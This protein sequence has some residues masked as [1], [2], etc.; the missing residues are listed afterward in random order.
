MSFLIA[1]RNVL[2]NRRRTIVTLLLSIVATFF[3]IFYGAVFNGMFDKA[4]KDSLEVYSDYMEIAGKGYK[5]K[6]SYEH[7]IHDA[8]K[9]AHYLSQMP[10]IESFSER[11][12]A[13]ALLATEKRSLGAFFVG[14][15]P[16]KEPKHSKL[17]E[18]LIEGRWL[19][20]DDKNSIVLGL[21]LAKKLKLKVGDKV[22]FLATAIDDSFT[23]DNLNIVGIFKT[24]FVDIDKRF[25]MLD[26]PY[27][28]SMFLSDNLATHFAVRP[29]NIDAVD[30]ISTKITA[31]LPNTETET[32][33]SFVKSITDV[34][35]V[36]KESAYVMF[37][38]L[39]VI[40]FFVFMVYAMIAILA[41]NKEIGIM[42]AVGARPKTIIAM[43][44]W[45]AF[46]IGIVAVII[47]GILG[48]YLIWYLEHNP[49]I[50]TGKIA[51]L[52][53]E[54]SKMGLTIEPKIFTDFKWVY[55]FYPALLVLMMNLL[56]IIYPT[57]KV[58]KSKPI[59]E[60]H[61]I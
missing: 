12:E 11:Y 47:G 27:M 31:A 37:G 5:D 56:S 54:S 7:L 2:L 16:L 15:D 4:M 14:I 19:N 55:V 10:E 21:G 41:R 48:G 52:Y 50:L 1:W 32:W 38:V 39:Y 60:I 20:P 3:L 33:H 24:N 35:D 25:A 34:I 43:F 44:F 61:A 22:S 46:I 28:D 53:A 51:D 9:V 59:D 45:E 57:I 26:R 58:L 36:K 13:F 18:K 29:K 42:R 8:A 6:P 30:T 49:I 17:K 40:I 23:A